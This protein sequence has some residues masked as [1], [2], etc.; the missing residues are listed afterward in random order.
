MA[1]ATPKCFLLGPASVCGEDYHGYPVQETREYRNETYFNS[2]FNTNIIDIDGASNGFN[3]Y[4]CVKGQAL[5]NALQR[6]RFHVS[7][8]CSKIVSDA[9]TA[10]CAVQ[11]FPSKPLPPSGPIMCSSACN[12]VYNSAKSI[13]EDPVA[14]PSAGNDDSLL[15]QISATCSN[16]AS[17]L[18]QND[19]K[20][21][22]GTTIEKKICGKDDF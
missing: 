7:F 17:L 6:R 12:Q 16:Y 9:L 14:C 4:G 21:T 8:F 19:N 18:P 15:S 10:R 5:T 11:S 3:R 1:L 20:C 22:N 13:L 2:Y